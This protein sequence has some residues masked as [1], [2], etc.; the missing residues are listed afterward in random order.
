MGFKTQMVLCLGDW[1]YSHLHSMICYGKSWEILGHT[2]SF[3][4]KCH[5]KF[6]DLV[7]I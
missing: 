1:G 3:N 7:D 6:N 4:G 2:K 5:G